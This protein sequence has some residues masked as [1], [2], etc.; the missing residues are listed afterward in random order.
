[1]AI[2]DHPLYPKWLAALERLIVAKERVREVATI[3]PQAIGE[4]EF[5][6]ARARLAFL[7]IADEI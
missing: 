5:E 1:M 3:S 4:A 6:L 7:Q 2:K